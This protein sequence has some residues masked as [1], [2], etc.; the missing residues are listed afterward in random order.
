MGF[1]FFSSTAQSTVLKVLSF[2]FLQKSISSQF[3][4]KKADALHELLFAMSK[5]KFS[6][7]FLVQPHTAPV[8]LLPQLANI[9]KDSVSLT[10]T[11]F[12]NPLTLCLVPIP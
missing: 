2:G 8:S 1:F 11:F 9:E 3:F 5:L 10:Y 7:H 4:S 6:W 12:F